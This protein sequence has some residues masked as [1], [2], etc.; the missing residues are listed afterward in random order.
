MSRR[1]IASLLA[2]SFVLLLLQLLALLVGPVSGLVAAVGLAPVSMLLLRF[3]QT[4]LRPEWIAVV[5]PASCGLVAV[6]I[7]F[8]SEPGQP[9][10]LWFAPLLTLAGS[11][12]TSGID[13]RRS[14]R[15]GL[16][17]R[18]LGRGLSF[19]CPRC[20]LL[21]CDHSCW[22]F[23]SSR[24]QLCEQNKVPIFP[25]D[26][27]WWDRQFGPRTEHGRCQ[28][29][30]TPAADADLRAC[31]KCGRAQC[32]DCWDAVNGQCSRCKWTVEELPEVLR[33][34]MLAVTPG[35][36]RAPIGP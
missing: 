36:A 4:E 35:Q 26:G 6:V 14:R 11:W 13:R 7:F 18:R 20:G 2:C 33:Q 1:T 34:Y 9:P 17:N 16:C 23:E 19:T 22:V 24:C 29:C 25:P 30:L 8:L 28:L 31:R 12:A 15:C 5:L 27:R 3:F 21:V 32:R 10:Y